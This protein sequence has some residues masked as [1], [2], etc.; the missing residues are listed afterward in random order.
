M[1]QKK[2]WLIVVAIASLVYV[3]IHLGQSAL[4]LEFLFHAQLPVGDQRRSWVVLSVILPFGI[5]LGLFLF[6]TAMS[7]STKLVTFLG[8]CIVYA[9]LISNIILSMSGAW[10]LIFPLVLPLVLLERWLGLN[11]AGYLAI[12][13]TY[14][15]DI[16]VPVLVSIGF[17]IAIVG[18][19]QVVKAAKR[20]S[21]AT[22]GLY[23][24]TRHPQHLGIILWALGF[25]LWGAHY[26]DFLIWFTLAYTLTLLAWH[27]ERNLEKQFGPRYLAYQHD[28][29]FMLPLVPKRGTLFRISDSKEVAILAGI[30]VAGIV[31]ISGLFYLFSVPYGHPNI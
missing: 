3:I 18:L 28:T 14:A 29:P 8:S 19:V 27:E 21:L 24:T 2:A 20:E 30:Y 12:R 22:D 25:A 9:A 11:K 26:F 15:Q 10:L 4:D 31:I 16:I 6:S 1:S 23:T 7:R 5:A 13:A 17:A